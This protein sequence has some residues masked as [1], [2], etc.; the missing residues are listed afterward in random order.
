VVIF[1]DFFEIF[2]FKQGICDRIF[3]FQNIFCKIGENSLP[4]NYEEKI[5]VLKKKVV[6]NKKS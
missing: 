2:F 4:K 1:G 3:F 6:I 5:L